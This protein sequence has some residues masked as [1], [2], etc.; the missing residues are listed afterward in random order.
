M[1]Q[2]YDLHGRFYIVFLHCYVLLVL[3]D[4]YDFAVMN[5][6]TL[7]RR[8]AAEL[9]ALQV[10]V[11]TS[12]ISHLTSYIVHAGSPVEAGERASTNAAVCQVCLVGVNVSGV[13]EFVKPI[14]CEPLL[15]T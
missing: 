1:L 5:I 9:S 15:S 3:V 11:F 2:F 14:P 6:H 13:T 8:F 12:S 4:S 7:L 10:E